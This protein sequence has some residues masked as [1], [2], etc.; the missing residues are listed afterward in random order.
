MFFSSQKPL[1]ISGL[2]YQEMLVYSAKLKVQNYG[3]GNFNLF[4]AD[5]VNDLLGVMN[6]S[7]CKNRVIIEYPSLRGEQGSDFR[8]LSIAMEIVDLPPLLVLDEPTLDFDPAISVSIMQCMQTLAKRGHA[9]VLSMTKP[10]LQEV[11]LLDSLCI[12]SEGYSIFSAHPKHIEAHFCSPGMGYV[13]KKGVDIVDFAMDISAGI[14][15]PNNQ[16]EADLPAIMQENF[17]L[18]KYYKA[19]HSNRPGVASHID[20]ASA[21]NPSYSFMGGYFRYNPVLLQLY[22]TYIV[23]HRALYTKIKDFEVIKTSIMASII[24]SLFAGY[25]Q[26]NQGSYGC[27]ATNFITL[28]YLNTTNISSLMFFITMFTFAFPFINVHVLTQKLQLFRYEQSA[29]VCSIPQFFLGMVL[30]EV[31]FLII[32]TFIFCNIIYW[33]ASFG[34]GDENYRFFMSSMIG[35]S[36][37]GLSSAFMWSAILKKELI[38]RDFFYM[39]LTLLAL[40]SGFPFQI[41][42]MSDFLANVCLTNP[43]R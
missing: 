9:I 4:V 23:L 1:Y 20:H 15:R 14:E 21:F 8:R 35:N 11:A 29:G 18:S 28:P 25:L 41:P 16:R 33:M 3:K 34:L 31:P 2:T 39:S 36:M 10:Y 38:V 5:R 7:V 32:Y 37:V 17:E 27:C 43:L 6:L 13:L 12:L 24:L 40:L 22:R 42:Q 30:S 19:P 26:Y